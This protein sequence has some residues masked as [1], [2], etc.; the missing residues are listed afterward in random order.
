M[1]TPVKFLLIITAFFVIN[2][3]T[4]EDLDRITDCWGQSSVVEIQY[5][6]DP[7]NAKKITYSIKYEGSGT[8][9]DV[10]WSFGD[11]KAAVKGLKVTH[12]YETAGTYEVKADI[13]VKKNQTDCSLNLKKDVQV[14]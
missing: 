13:A 4:E 8:L 9:N 11:G 5:S 14:N 2:S 7:L 3:C 1:K 12:I 10:T 6:L